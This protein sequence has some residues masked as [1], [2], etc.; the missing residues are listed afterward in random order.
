MSANVQ[1]LPKAFAVWFR[2]LDRWDVSSFQEIEWHW[3][4]DVMAPIGSVLQVYKEK[5]DRKLFPFS[6]LQPITIHFDGSI[7][8]RD[9]DGVTDYSMELF[10]ARPGDIVVAKIDLKNGAVGIIPEGWENVV[11]TGHFAVYKPDRAKLLPEYLH[12]IIQTTFFKAH[13]WRNKVGAEGRKEVK[14]EFFESLEIP[15]PPLPIQQAIVARWRQA[16]DEVEAAESYVRSIEAGIDE[17]FLKALGLSPQPPAQVP[18]CFAV[19]WE[20]LFQ[21]SGRATFLLK[22]AHLTEC[23]YPVVTGNECLAEVK[24]GCSASPAASPTSLEIL[25]ISAVTR[26]AF[27]PFARKYFEDKKEYRE[28]F[29]LLAGDVL[30]CRTNGTLE[31]VGMSALVAEEMKD[32]IFPD[33][34]IRLR[35]RPNILPAYLWKVLQSQPLR[36]QIEAVARTAVG[37]YAI[38]SD[39]VW[40]LRIPLP[41]LDVQREI[42]RRVEEGRAEIARVREE[43]RRRASAAQAE[44]EALILGTESVNGRM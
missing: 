2:D 38:G 7:D 9:V 5:V 19:L 37:N 42:V 22:Q 36:L 4:I 23:K 24:H 21:W 33:K 40:N 25:K 43:A 1:R 8:R 27:D 29:N 34:V 15:L 3:P 41:P 26:G 44:L 14:L 39:D 13:L 30:L 32:L 35:A 11:V 20:E 17:E 16:Q 18:I 31:Y 6:A 12:R 10:F 28:E